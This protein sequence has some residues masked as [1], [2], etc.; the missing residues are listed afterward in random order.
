MTESLSETYV[1]ILWERGHVETLV[2]LI[3]KVRVM[4]HAHSRAIEQRR[5]KVSSPEKRHDQ[6]LILTV[7]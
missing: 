1:I 4:Q 5:C 7:S 3:I 2:V 6:E